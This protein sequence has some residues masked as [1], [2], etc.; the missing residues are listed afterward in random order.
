MRLVRTFLILT[1]GL[2]NTAALAQD[3]QPQPASTSRPAVAPEERSAIRDAFAKEWEALRKDCSQGLEALENCAVAI[4]TG[5]PLY[6]ALGSLA[7]QS[8]FGFG[9]A[10]VG[11]RNFV[12]SPWRL[13][14]NADALAA[15]TGSWRTGTSFTFDRVAKAT[16]GGA[17]TI[18]HDDPDQ[19][20]PNDRSKTT[21]VSAYVQATSLEKLLFFGIGPDSGLAGKSR[22][23]VSQTVVGGSVV[24]PIPSGRANLSL[25]GS[26]NGRFFHV[27]G[28]SPG[29]SPSIADLYTEATAPGLG[30][31]KGRFVQ[32]TES[33]RAQPSWFWRHLRPSYALTADQFVSDG[34]SDASF[35]RLSVEFTHEFPFYETSRSTHGLGSSTSNADGCPDAND[36][37]CDSISDDRDGSVSV[38]LLATAAWARQGHAVP[39]YLQPTLGGGGGFNGMPILSGFSDYRFRAP[40]AI[41]LQE[42]FDHSVWG[43]LG[44]VLMAEQGKVA[45]RPR[46]LGFSNLEHTVAAGL[47]MGAG[48]FP[49]VFLVI[50]RSREG[51][52]TVFRMD[53][54]LPGGTSRP[55]LF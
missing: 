27:R 30:R 36:V 31:G 34:K 23:T 25:L 3:A 13:L 4:I 12:A 15:R 9:A 17:V 20:N 16:D 52:R 48:R 18:S 7:P 47:T 37:L 53:P 14:W 54:S 51:Q 43:P 11:R 44:V 50:A 26:V 39:F 38:T 33:V 41:A 5:Q 1:I 10:L 8:G 55:S 29:D 2:P 24:K 46:D 28:S 22:W 45:L 19:P 49:L 32:F 21:T 6:L 40:N 42:R 35:N